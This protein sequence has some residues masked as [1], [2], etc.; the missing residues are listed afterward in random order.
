MIVYS[1]E[2]PEV[3]MILLKKHL[4]NRGFFSETFNSRV[5]EERGIKENFVQDNHSLSVEKGTLRGLHFQVAPKAQG[6]LVR[7]IRG[8][9]LDVAVDIRKGSPTFGKFIAEELTAEKWNALYIPVGF[10]H[11]FITKEPNTEVLYKTTNYYS[12]EH[13]RGIFWDDPELNI[14]WGTKDVVLSKKDTQYPTL[15]ESP[16]YFTYDIS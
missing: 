8:S 12:P 10:A 5:L 11:G 6:K 15:S 14:S 7:V 3:K 2:I 16:E 13:E 9:I 1:L 4:D